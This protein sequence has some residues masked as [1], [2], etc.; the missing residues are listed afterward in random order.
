M[1]EA[2]KGEFCGRR[3]NP[4]TM[5]YELS[6]NSGTAYPVEMAQEVEDALLLHPQEPVVALAAFFEWKDR[7]S[8]QAREHLKEV[9]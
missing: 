8:K 5:M 4:N 3:L 6:D 9:R 7:L 2:V 1:G